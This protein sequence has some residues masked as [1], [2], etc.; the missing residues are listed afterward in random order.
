LIS[1]ESSIIA[2][3]GSSS[4]MQAAISEISSF[5]FIWSAFFTMNRRVCAKR[6][7]FCTASAILSAGVSPA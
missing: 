5:F 2:V 7:W 4:P 3:S 6:L 1:S